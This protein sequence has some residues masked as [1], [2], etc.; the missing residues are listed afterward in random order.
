MLQPS[1]FSFTRDCFKVLSVISNEVL[2]LHTLY[3]H[4]KTKAVITSLL[5]KTRALSNESDLSAFQK[6][7]I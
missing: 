4:V 3:F 6:A 1:D 5:L 7:H 2:S